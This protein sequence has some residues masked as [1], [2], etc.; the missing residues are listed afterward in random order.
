M[1]VNT[2][3]KTEELDEKHIED[4]EMLQADLTTIL[5]ETTLDGKCKIPFIL[6]II[7]KIIHLGKMRDNNILTFEMNHDVAP[8]LYHIPSPLLSTKEV[9]MNIIS[10]TADFINDL[11]YEKTKA[12]RILAK[13][14][15][16]N[17]GH[18]QTEK[19]AI[20]TSISSTILPVSNRETIP[21]SIVYHFHY[22][23]LL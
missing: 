23:F 17:I 14:M 4:I 18:Q 21:V 8:L 19:E 13:T 6:I 5:S 3:E 1:Q 22:S 10:K 2:T 16:T 12:Q 11:P 9:N 7:F 20:T 15:A